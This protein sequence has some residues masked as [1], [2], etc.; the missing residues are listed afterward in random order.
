MYDTILVATDGSEPANRAVQYAT[1]LA[2]TFDAT[3]CALAVVDTQRYGNSML[4]NADALVEDLEEHAESTLEEV[5]GRTDREVTTE[6]RLGSPHE[7][8]VDYADSV[9][10]DLIVLGNLGLAGGGEIGSTAERVVR[11]GDRPVLTV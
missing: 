7:E 9:D 3:L 2:S 5:A 1:D 10:A 4:A 11:H 6:I 8:I